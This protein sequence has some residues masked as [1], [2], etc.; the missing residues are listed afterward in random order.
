[1]AGNDFFLSFFIP[2]FLTAKFWYGGLYG[3]YSSFIAYGLAF[4]IALIPN[5][6][7]YWLVIF[8]VLLV[9][10][11][12]LAAYQQIPY[13]QI[14][15]QIISQAKLTKDDLLIYLITSGHNLLTKMPIY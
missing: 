13:P 10:L 11:P 15:K 6:K 4:F 2:F 5:K 7:F 8:S 3:R 9:F 14:Q 12:C 1:M